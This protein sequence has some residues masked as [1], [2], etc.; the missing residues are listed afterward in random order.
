MYRSTVADRP[1][2]TSVY[3]R[4][5]EDLYLFGAYVLQHTVATGTLTVT[6]NTLRLSGGVDPLDDDRRQKILD[7][8]ALGEVVHGHGRRREHSHTAGVWRR[9]PTKKKRSHGPQQEVDVDA[10]NTSAT[11]WRASS[12]RSVPPSWP[13]TTAATP[14]ASSLHGWCTFCSR[15][16]PIDLSAV[17]APVRDA[18]A[19]RLRTVE[20]RWV[21]PDQAFAS[22]SDL[23]HTLQYLVCVRRDPGAAKEVMLRHHA[24]LL[25]L[26]GLETHLRETTELLHVQYP[27]CKWLVR[28][29]DHGSLWS[30]TKADGTVVLSRRLELE[31]PGP[32]IRAAAGPC[33][34]C[35]TTRPSLTPW[36]SWR[37]SSCR[38]SAC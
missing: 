8:T 27:W 7:A 5:S 14:T 21:G 38:C 10:P 24:R 29:E 19:A 32:D 28:T 31:T 4:I 2:N 12:W 1:I 13:C 23:L 35:P 33:S 34:A 16:T 22:P 3:V 9:A 18:L 6:V 36:A 30:V 25:S 37:T 17:P 15:A 11:I 26:Y 20:K